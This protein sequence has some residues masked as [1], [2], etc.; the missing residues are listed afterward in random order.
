VTRLSSLGTHEHWNNAQEKKHSRNL[1]LDKG[2][3]LVP[4]ALGNAKTD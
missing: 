3:E 2:I 4:V 1:G